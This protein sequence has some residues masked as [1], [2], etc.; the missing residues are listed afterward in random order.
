MKKYLVLYHSTMRAA[1]IMASHT[2]EEGKAEMAAWMAWAQRSGAA[3][4]DL[5]SPVGPARRFPSATGS[6]AG[7]TSVGGYSILQADDERAL[8]ALLLGHPHFSMPGGTI[9]TF[10]FL[11][12]PGS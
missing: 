6:T 2:P 4:A 8:Q 3:I 5:G 1:D 10:E 11:P 12:M 7:E 9:E